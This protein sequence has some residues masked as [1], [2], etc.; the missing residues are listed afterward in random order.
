[1]VY[2]KCNSQGRNTERRRTKKSIGNTDNYGQVNTTVY[3]AGTG[4]DM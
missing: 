3:I 4:A 1:M 2:T